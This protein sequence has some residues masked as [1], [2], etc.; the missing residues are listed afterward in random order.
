MRF[1]KIA[2]RLVHCMLVNR[3]FPLKDKNNQ[4]FNFEKFHKIYENYTLKD[5]QNEVKNLVK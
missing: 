4:I 2:F 3:L 1:I 5:Y